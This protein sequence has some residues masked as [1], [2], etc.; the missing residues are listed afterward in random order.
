MTRHRRRARDETGSATAELAILTPL[1]I[2]FL[3]LVVALGRLSGARGEV[4]GAAAQAARAA[5]I[6]RDPSAA[7]LAAQ[8]TAAASL[9]SEH[10]TCAHLGV[11]VDTAA[12]APGGTVAVTVS[13]TV[14]LSTLT[15]LHLPAT[16]TLTD[17][18][19]EPIDTYRSAT[20]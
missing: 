2:L 19:V 16:R 4:D 5:S 8:Q 3:L 9:A 1:L 12:F 18:F 15:G 17:R 6:T 10:L 13:C 14:G 7:T 11:A 20:P